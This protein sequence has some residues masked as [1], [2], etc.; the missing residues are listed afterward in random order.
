MIE[1]PQRIDE[2]VHVLLWQVDEIAPIA[3]GLMIG[4]F[5]GA[6]LILMGVGWVMTSFY[7]RFRDAKPDGFALHYLY[8]HGFMPTR[9]RTAPN[10]FTR[11]YLP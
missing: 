3:I 4:M 10:P 1:I 7:R 6:P 11:Q 8:W 2:P 9:S 5:I